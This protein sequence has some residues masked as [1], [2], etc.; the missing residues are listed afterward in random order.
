MLFIDSGGTH[1]VNLIFL[2][3][4]ILGFEFKMEKTLSMLDLAFKVIYV[5]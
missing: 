3:V 2:I 5:D 1:V 4:M